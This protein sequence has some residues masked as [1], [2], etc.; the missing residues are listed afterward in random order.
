MLTPTLARVAN[1]LL[2]SRFLLSDVVY[3]LGVHGFKVPGNEIPYYCEG[4]VAQSVWSACGVEGSPDA[5]SLEK[6]FLVEC[7]ELQGQ[8]PSK[9]TTTTTTTLL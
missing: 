9:P 5:A 6:A 8:L 1:T 3:G 7:L 4:L 2:P